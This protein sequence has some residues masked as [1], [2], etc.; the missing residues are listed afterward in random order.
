[1]PRLNSIFVAAVALDLAAFCGLAPAQGRGSVPAPGQQR[2][3]AAAPAQ[4]AEP[5]AKKMTTEQLLALWE[6]QSQLLKDLQVAIYRV[7][8]LPDWDEELHYE[9][10]AAFKTPQFAYLDFKKVK[11]KVVP[12]PKNPKKSKVVDLVNSN[13]NPPTRVTENYERIVCTGKEVWHYRYDKKEANVYSLNRDAQR[14]ALDEGPLPFLF[15][16]KAQEAMARYQMVLQDE[17][18][19]SFLVAIKPKLKND[20]E[21]FSLAWVRLDRK[22]LLPVRITLLSPDGQ[23]VRDFQLSRISA[24]QGVK[25]ALFHGEKLPGW[26]VQWNPAEPEESEAS[27]QPQRRPKAR[28]AAQRSRGLDSNQPR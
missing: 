24:N 3:A 10:S 1:M 13:T 17:D 15:N 11:T 9:G 22:Y 14:R 16:M 12:D 6:R 28:E 27:R 18:A 23:S 20:Q 7:D 4:G 25:S 2:P 5:A 8:K 19:K 26:T 21:S